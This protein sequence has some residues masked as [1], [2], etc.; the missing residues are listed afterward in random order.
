LSTKP[1]DNQW[2]TMCISPWALVNSGALTS[3]PKFD[4]L[5]KVRKYV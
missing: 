4:H 2:K 1:V 3:C 5:K